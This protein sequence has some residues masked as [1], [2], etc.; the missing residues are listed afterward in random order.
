MKIFNSNKG[1]VTV[2]L[3]LILVPTL[4]ITSI[5]VDVSRVYLVTSLAES[6]GDLSLNGLLSNYDGDLMN[7]Y[8]FMGS[9]QNMDDKMTASE[10]DFK[11]TIST[12]INEGNF[13]FLATKVEGE[14]KL[15]NK[16][17]EY[18]LSQ[19]AMIKKSIVEFMKYRGPIEIVERIIDKIKNSGVEDF[20]KFSEMDKFEDLRKQKDKF[21][22]KESEFSNRVYNTYL[23][24]DEYTNKTREYGIDTVESL[25]KLNGKVKEVKKVY[26]FAH[27]KLFEKYVYVNGINNDADPLT[28]MTKQLKPKSHYTEII[29][30][31][32]TKFDSSDVIS[33]ETV[34]K[35]LDEMDTDFQ[36]LKTDVDTINGRL[37]SN[38]ILKT[39]PGINA[40]E[41]NIWKWWRTFEDATSGS[42]MDT[43]VVLANEVGQRY[44]TLDMYDRVKIEGDDDGSVKQRLTDLITEVKPYMA[45]NIYKDGTG[46]FAKFANNAFEITST[47]KNNLDYGQEKINYLGSE[48]TLNE[49]FTDVSETLYNTKK[50]NE[51]IIELLDLIIEGEKGGMFYLDEKVASLDDLKKLAKEYEQELKNWKQEADEA[52]DGSKPDKPEDDPAYLDL[53]DK[54]E[55]KK[56]D[57]NTEG[58][59]G[60]VIGNIASAVTDENV[61]I[62]KDRLIAIKEGFKEMNKGISK[63]T[64]NDFEV[65]GTKKA[66]VS[67]DTFRK[68]LFK[69]AYNSNS[70]K[71][72]GLTTNSEIESNSNSLFDS[73]FQNEYKSLDMERFKDINKS[74]TLIPAEDR[75]NIPELYM[76]T[77]KMFKGLNKDDLDKKKKEVSD[78]KDTAE[79]KLEEAL[80]LSRF[81]GEETP[82]VKRE[83]TSA[84]GFSAE[85][86]FSAGIGILQNILD[87]NLKD[88]R[89]DLYATAYAMSMFSYATYDNEGRFKL[90]P[91]SER[92]GLRSQDA[93]GKYASKDGI[94][95][96]DELN[97]DVKFKNR[98]LTGM[99]ISKENN[100]AFMAEVEYLLF[101]ETDKNSSNVDK[102]YGT[103]FA[104]KFPLNFVSAMSNF[105]KN[106]SLNSVAAAIQGATA[107]IVPIPLTKLIVITLLTTLETSKDLDRLEAG[108]PVEIYKPKDTD[109]IYEIPEISDL[110]GMISEISNPKNDKN[111]KNDKG[112]TYSDYMTLFTALS[113]KGANGQ[114]TYQRMAE[115]IQT[116]I[117]HKSKNDGYSLKNSQVYYKLKSKLKVDPILFTLPIFSNY[118]DGHLEFEDWTT[119][120]VDITRGY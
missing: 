34:E 45:K 114:R 26:N 88:M 38:E 35:V 69:N 8:G 43:L 53:T 73:M 12:K 91:K 79:Q 50:N 82:T 67:L 118:T 5:F 9:A 25:E 1:A 87:L 90:L 20:T 46:Q 29:N 65:T 113:L 119:F 15:I 21:Y 104:M 47:Y 86:V 96:S 115:V 2:F 95:F 3:T 37:D 62:L 32:N 71:Y 74:P 7:W 100:A 56:R 10:D 85:D 94:W 99:R 107:G 28:S 22:E 77:Y 33:K 68:N 58:Q 41:T 75:V 78:A 64:Y 4:L 24:L 13:N 117:G 70:S 101:G 49:A 31:D 72:A 40:S 63:M 60:T 109:W 83:F 52:W 116:N 105:W 97:K 61:Q 93:E 110:P 84:G 112:L 76:Y 23:K 92:E 57:A 30:K 19:P 54:D 16:V 66:S 51:E 108:F 102:A 44:L 89:D 81:K 111:L 11:N 103:I 17:E 39:K 42:E 14:D 48:T 18:N 36:K 80:K 6:A 27:D 55:I 106:I 59:D 98:T 120:D